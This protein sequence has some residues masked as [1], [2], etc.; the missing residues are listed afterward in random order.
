MLGYSFPANSPLMKQLSGAKEID[1]V[2]S[3]LEE[4]LVAATIEHWDFKESKHISLRD[5]CFVNCINKLSDRFI[6][7]GM[8]NF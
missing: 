2:Y 3:G 8:I 7:S 5:A 6:E 4:I 1:I